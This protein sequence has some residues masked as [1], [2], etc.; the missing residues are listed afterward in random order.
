MIGCHQQWAPILQ[1]P[2]LLWLVALALWRSSSHPLGRGPGGWLGFLQRLFPGTS[3][4]RRDGPDGKAVQAY[5]R[6]R[7]M[8]SLATYKTLMKAYLLEC[9]QWHFRVIQQGDMVLSPDWVQPRPTCSWHLGVFL[10]THVASCRLQVY[11]TGDMLSR[12]CDL[13]YDVIEDGIVPDTATS[14]TLKQQEWHTMTTYFWHFH[15]QVMYG[16]LM[17]FAVKCGREDLSERLFNVASEQPQAGAQRLV[18]RVECGW[19]AP[20]CHCAREMMYKTTYGSS[21]LQ[22]LA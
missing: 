4:P 22:A 16:C 14:L 21:D 3:R 19:S 10:D 8:T 9:H 15:I 1:C 13:Y 20:H 5:L 6:D 17:K 11:V 2:G 7:K 18:A 12:A